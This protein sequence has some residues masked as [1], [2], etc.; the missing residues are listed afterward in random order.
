[1]TWP[2]V[3]LREIHVFL[4]LADELHFGRTAE[5]LALTPSRV[6]QTIRALEVRVGGRLFDRTSRRV[7]L[8]PLGEEFRHRIGPVF[9][10]MERAYA[11]TREAVTGVAGTLRV[12]MNTRMTGGLHFT[13]IVKTFETRHPACTVSVIDIG[14]DRGLVEWLRRGDADA[15][16]LRLPVSA[17]DLVI[18]PVL[19]HEPRVAMIATTHPLAQQSVISYE[20]LADY[21]CAVQYVPQLPQEFMDEFVP[22]FTPSGRPLRRIAPHSLDESLMRAALGELAH[23]TV[24]SM[25]SHHQH[26]NVTMVSISDLPPSKAVLAW[27]RENRSAKV[28][29]FT[30]A[31]IDVLD[32]TGTTSDGVRRD[33]RVA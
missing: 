1:M 29:A 17:P 23:V 27:L 30:R 33:F 32:R 10:Q 15:L 8:T 26:P 7:N 9:E 16:A 4:T 5:R 6:S 21:D 2:A 18:G 3:E 24:P 22:P 13:E 14:F 28:S 11:A 12:G 20:D 31:A 25:A 19:S